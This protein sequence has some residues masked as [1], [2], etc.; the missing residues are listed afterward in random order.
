MESARPML[1]ELRLCASRCLAIALCAC[2]GLAH[3]QANLPGVAPEMARA[4]Q[5]L[6]AGRADEAWRLL[7]PHEFA[8]AGREDFD[9]L[10]GVAALDSG[11]ADLATLVFERVLAVS[12]N[13]A[14]ARLDMGRA[15]FALGDMERARTEFESVMRFD[16]P[17]GARTTIERYLAAIDQRTRGRRLRLTGHV[18]ASFGHDSNVNSSTSQGS[19]Y[20]PLFGVNF[21]LASTAVKRADAFLAVGGGVDAAYELGAGYS[22]IAGAD[23]RQRANFKADTFDYRNVDYRGGLQYAGERDNLRLQV[24]R[25]DYELDNASYRRTQSTTGEW[26][27]T[28]DARTQFSVYGQDSRIRYVQAATRANSSNLFMYGAGAV[29]VLDE[30]TR[31]FAYAS[32]FRGDEVAT[33]GRSD[34]DRRLWGVRAGVQRALR[35]D[36]DWFATATVQK[37]TYE[38]Q[39]PLFLTTRQDLQYD[40]SIGLNWQVARDWSLRPQMAYTRN[41]SNVSL[42]DFERYEVSVTVRRDFR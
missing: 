20:V 12:P 22:A 32:A 30:S 35:A 40:L 26:R 19:L 1:T 31:T 39:N 42:N 18:D 4:E 28:L 24:G 16:P 3:A 9:Y 33:D 29:R 41:D 8:Q 11:R 2:A 13:H 14:A 37:S 34:G 25:N 10:L 17:P 38:Q 15:Y 23:L 36:A 21:T 6:R 7:S 5:L 27:H